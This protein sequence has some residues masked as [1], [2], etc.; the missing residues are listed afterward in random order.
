MCSILPTY[1]GRWTASSLTSDLRGVDAFQECENA[2]LEQRCCFFVEIAEAAV[3][4]QVTVAWMEKQ[5][6]DVAAW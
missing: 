5:L 2:L 1:L 6:G 3:R 4:E